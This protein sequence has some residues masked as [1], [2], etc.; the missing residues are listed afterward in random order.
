MSSRNALLN[1]FKTI[2]GMV[3]AGEA[4]AQKLEEAKAGEKRPGGLL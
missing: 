1:Y 3:A 2:K 4:A